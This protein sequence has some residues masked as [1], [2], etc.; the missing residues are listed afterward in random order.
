MHVRS[1][2][3]VGFCLLAVLVGAGHEAAAQS[4]PIT[5][6]STLFAGC[7]DLVQNAPTGDMMRMGACAGAVSTAL[8]ISRQLRR[9]CPPADVD[10]IAAARRFIDFVEER[11]ARQADQFG[12]LMLTALADRWPC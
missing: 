11:P 2:K 7:Q 10:V 8:D 9:S 12:T 1:S 3:L 5:A 6:T 4:A